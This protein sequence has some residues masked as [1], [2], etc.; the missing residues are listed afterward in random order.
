MLTREEIR[1]YQTNGYLV[2]EEL[3]RCER[4][5]H[6]KSV[7]DELVMEGSKLTDQ[8]PHWSLELDTEGRPQ[9]GLLHKIQGVCM[10][11]SRAL[12]LSA[13]APDSGCSR[14][15]AQNPCFIRP[16]TNRHRCVR[17]QVFSK[18]A[19]RRHINTLASRQLL[20]CHPNQ[21][22]HKL[23]HLSGRFGSGQ[24]LFASRTREPSNTQNSRTP[25]RLNHARN[26]DSSRCVAGR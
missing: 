4:L 17:Y 12:T 2:L 13:R 21:L 3:I 11:D 9:E 7:F 5:D 23:C 1:K 24:W 14:S 20:L 15:V 16:R 6:Y 26:L 25:P 22:H 10:V 19:L 8:K 18:A